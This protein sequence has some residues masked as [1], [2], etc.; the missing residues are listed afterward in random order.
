MARMIWHEWTFLACYWRG[1]WKSCRLE[2]YHGGK[3]TL[4][5]RPQDIEDISQQPDYNELNG[6]CI[7]VTALEVLYDL[8]R[9]D[10]D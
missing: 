9:E 7:G 6:K 3:N 2:A 8:W 10:D 1:K 5:N 4:K